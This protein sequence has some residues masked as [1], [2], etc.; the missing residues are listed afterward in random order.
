MR[1]LGYG[2]GR[3]EC[4]RMVVDRGVREYP[5]GRGHGELRVYSG[6]EVGRTYRG[7]G[8]EVFQLGIVLLLHVL[9]LLLE[10]RMLRL[11]LIHRPR[12]IAACRVKVLHLLLVSV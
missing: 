6:V 2:H 3:G 5:Q 7:H 12:Q 10:A 4:G 8:G 1:R 11:G 9:R